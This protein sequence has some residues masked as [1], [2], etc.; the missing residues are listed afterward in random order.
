MVLLLATIAPLCLHAQFH[1][2]GQGGVNPQAVHSAQM[3]AASMGAPPPEIGGGVGGGDMIL[4]DSYR[5]AFKQ[6]GVDVSLSRMDSKQVD[7]WSRAIHHEDGSYTESSRDESKKTLEQVTKSK[8]GTTLQSRL[9]SL[10]QYSRPSEVMIYD[11][12]G[13]FKYRGM[14]LYDTLGR[15]REEQIYDVKGTL[16]RRKIQ[17]YAANGQK[18]PVHCVDLVDNVPEDLKLVITRDDDRSNAAP[19]AAP[20]KKPGLFE[21]NQ[22]AN[23]GAAP[24]PNAVV[25]NEPLNPVD[26]AVSASPPPAQKKGLNFGKLFGGGKKSN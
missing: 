18:V 12:R 5:N 15:F 3:Q 22:K 24:V 14:L 8:N 26:G 11:G 2:P 17:E 10:D 20:A 25:S 4:T 13:Q 7:I 1:N 19:V 21:R 9:I 6:A 23:Q 16:L